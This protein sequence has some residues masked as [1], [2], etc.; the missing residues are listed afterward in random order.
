MII[1]VTAKLGKKLQITPPR[2]LPPAAN[3]FADWTAQLFV[4][5]RAQYILVTNTPSLYSMVMYGKGITNDSVFLQRAISRIGEVFRDD[6]HEFLFQRL[7]VPE[8]SVV[9]FSRALGPAVTGSMNELV[10]QAK[11]LLVQDGLS[12]FDASFRLNDIPMGQLGMDSPRRALKK[13]RW[14]DSVENSSYGASDW[15]N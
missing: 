8:S 11:A 10:L 3:P 2:S 14:P 6:D 13:L 15:W 5:D 9:T 4:A 1:R 7:V 12:P